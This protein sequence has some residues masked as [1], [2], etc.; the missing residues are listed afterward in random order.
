MTSAMVDRI[1]IRLIIDR[2]RQGAP[3]RYDRLK[4]AR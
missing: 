2:S 1:R 4:H 3:L